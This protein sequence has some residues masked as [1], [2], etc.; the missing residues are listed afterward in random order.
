[1]KM[2][3]YRPTRPVIAILGGGV[4]GASTAFHLARIAE[5]GSAEIL[6]I[7]PREEIGCG[8]AYSSDDPAHRINV[9]AARMTLFADDPGH[10]M[11]WLAE[12]Q[13]QMSPGTLTLRGEYFPERQVFGRYMRAHL[14]P[15]LRSGAIRHIRGAAA[16][17]TRGDRR[18]L[19]RMEDGTWLGAD[20][21]VLATSH[22]APRLPEPLA[23]VAGTPALVADPYDSARIAAIGS[24]DRVLVVGTGLTSADVVASLHHHGF[25]GR[26][27]ALSRHGLR[28]RGHGAV[29]RKCPAD[30]A[31]HPERTATALLRR[32]RAAVAA[33]IRDGESWHA[34]L[35]RV[36]EQGA[37]IWAGLGAGARGRVARHLRRYWDVHRFRVSPQVE[38]VLDQAV[39]AGT[40]DY[41][42][43]SLLGAREKDGALVV[44]WRPRGTT[45]VVTDRF[46][47]VVVTTGPDHA[48]VLRSNAALRSLALEGLVK[49]DPHGLGLRVTGGCRAV[50][51][52]GVASRTL[53]VAGPLA[54]GHVGELMG[55]PEVTRHAERVASVLAGELAPASEAPFAP[56]RRVV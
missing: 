18:Y 52:D 32:V 49:P 47:A 29:R 42:A 17:V 1:M 44:A 39:A 31:R 15:L 54:R 25:R 37:E 9:P 41:V 33:D 21:L 30:F 7:E 4:S 45:T 51:A 12:T 3:K 16:A 2:E 53:L 19:I 6:V 56:L 5:P 48:D 46:D 27:T 24:L 26:I 10:F 20:Y 13:I 34:A 28:S 23:R 8:L 14:A 35:D 11:A 22:P 43:A 38:G 36:R 40:L 55:I 50:G